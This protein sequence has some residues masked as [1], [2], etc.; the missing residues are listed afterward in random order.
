[1]ADIIIMSVLVY[2]LYSWFKNTKALQV[3]LG[4]A[5]LAILY[6]VTRT[7]G[8]FM[9]SW[10]LQELGTV[11]FVVIIVIF[12]VE[13]RQALY[14]FSLL[15]N[16]FGRQG[17]LQQLDLMEI[18][19]ALFSLAAERTGALVVFQRR[20]PIDEYLHHGV[21]LDSLAGGQLIA[22][23]FKNGTPLH[24]GAVLIKDG[25]VAQAS[26]HLPLSLNSDLPRHFGT[27]H[28]AG[29]G[30]VER[31]DAVAVMV[32]EERGEV[33]LA[34]SGE[35]EKVD[36]PESL[37]ARLTGLLSA[38]SPIVEKETVKDRLLRNFWPKVVTVGIVLVCWLVI[39]VKQGGVV[40]VTVPIKFHNLPDDVVLLKSV[41]EDVEVQLNVFSNLIPSPRQ[42]DIVADINLAKLHEGT[43][44]LP[45]RTEDF[46]LPLGVVVTSVK[47]SSVR[48]HAD[49]KIRR[50]LRIKTRI[51]GRLNGNSRV[52]RIAVEPEMVSVE[53][54]AS[55]VSR[56]EA[57]ETEPLDLAAVRKN[58][59]VERPLQRPAPMVNVLY[60]GQVKLRVITS[61]R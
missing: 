12:Q 29:I 38:A 34:V 17:N 6:M 51:F 47:P 33:T 58:E 45:I 36:S 30:L 59:V 42:L 54:P 7:L 48:I 11:V 27:R 46:K 61:E 8:L 4:L 44:M 5:F 2:Q 16:F 43:S 37:S 24:D 10:I 53:G 39:A 1:M 40:S 19:A 23:I 57:V 55:V 56:L 41:P 49:R 13:I 3:V 20:E 25:R 21:L 18:S 9:T 28:R 32:S 52:R 35:I 31:S 60:D 50:E 15:R 14:R 22:T 26:C